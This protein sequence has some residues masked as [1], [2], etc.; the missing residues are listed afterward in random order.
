MHHDGHSY[1]RPIACCI[2]TLLAVIGNFVA[3]RSLVA[4]CVPFLRGDTDASGKV[5]ISDGVATLNFLFLG[6]RAPL[7]ADAADA[8]DSGDL[9]VSDAVVTFN[10]LFL[11]GP[12]P[13]EPG[14]FACGG[15]P[16][17]FDGLGCEAFPVC[18]E[19]A[20]VV[21]DYSDFTNFTYEQFPG[22][23]F[24]PDPDRIFRASVKRI[25]PDEYRLERSILVDGEPEDPNCLPDAFGSCLLEVTLEPRLLSV[26]EAAALRD[27]F[28]A[29]EVFDAPDPICIC[30]VVDPCVILEFRWDDRRASDFLCS[31][32]RLSSD[33]VRDIVFLLDGLP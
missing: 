30:L 19:V 3:N 22:L 24:C 27:L 17:P 29:L 4:D 15:D 11:G 31:G 25:A 10:F 21:A 12:P 8:D 26:D 20:P 14:P 1:R 23:G 2:L 16:P 6:G 28:A 5:D 9:T 32:P 18:Q 33:T 13:A 7:C